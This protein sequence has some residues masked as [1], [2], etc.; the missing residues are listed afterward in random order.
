MDRINKTIGSKSLSPYMKIE[1]N[2]E[3]CQDF[4]SKNKSIKDLTEKYKISV[5]RV[6][7]IIFWSKRIIYLYKKY[8][9]IKEEKAKYLTEFEKDLKKYLEEKEAFKELDEQLKP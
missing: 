5:T 3:L 9:K 2:Y 8:K 1:R 7:H 6:R 4:A